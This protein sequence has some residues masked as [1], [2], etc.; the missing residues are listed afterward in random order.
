MPLPIWKPESSR[1]PDWL[2]RTLPRSQEF[3]Y[4]EETVHKYRLHTVCEEAKC[5]NRWECWSQKTATFLILGRECTRS[6]G[7][8]AIA[9]RAT[10]PPPD[11]QEPD[12]IASFVQELDLRYVVLT[13]VARDD[14]MDGGAAH[15]VRVIKAVHALPNK[16]SLEVLT[17][18]FAGNREALDQVIESG[19]H[20]F[21][22]NVETV[23]SLSSKVRHKADYDRSLAVLQHVAKRKEVL[24]VKVKSG[25]MVGF[26]EKSKCKRHCKTCIKPD[27]IV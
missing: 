19:V 10:P 12:R 20:V 15:L 21:N 22:H 11:P 18:D 24:C 8:C 17:S 27:A 2:H 25:L 3:V 23:R 26:G 4:T 16:I 6:C 5:P 13:M 9:F 1:F 14:L 7:F